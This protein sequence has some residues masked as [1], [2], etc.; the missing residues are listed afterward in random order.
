MRAIIPLKY[1]KYTLKGLEKQS[2]K[3]KKKRNRILTFRHGVFRRI[4]SIKNS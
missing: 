1:K 4:S 2:K 3:L